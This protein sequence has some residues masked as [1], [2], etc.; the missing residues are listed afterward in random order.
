MPNLAISAQ[1]YKNTAVTMIQRLKLNTQKGSTVQN[2]CY[3]L[4]YLACPRVRHHLV[5]YQN[6]C[7][8][9]THSAQDSAPEIFLP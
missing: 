4:P 3:T 7:S 2:K 1:N 5:N 9:E 6:L 8:M